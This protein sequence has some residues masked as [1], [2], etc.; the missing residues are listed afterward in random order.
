MMFKWRNR[1]PPFLKGKRDPTQTYVGKIG[2]STVEIGRYTYGIEYMQV[3]EWGEGA[4][5][6]IGAFCSIARDLRVFLGGNHRIEWSTTF[7][8]GHVFKDSLGSF[9]ISG[10][11]QTNGD[12]VI[13]N[14]VWLGEN[15]TV[16]SGVTIAD[17]TVVAANSTLTKSTKPYEVWGG[18]PCTG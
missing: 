18:Q 10:H 4:N 8:F 17:G 1:K 13:G 16:L 2:K 6:S 5:L 11:P 9:Q 14:D 7:P 15:V 3:R 12:V